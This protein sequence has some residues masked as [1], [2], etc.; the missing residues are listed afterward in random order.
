MKETSDRPAPKPDAAPVRPAWLLLAWTFG[1]GLAVVLAVR[2]LTGPAS[3]SEIADMPAGSPQVVACLALAVFL[4]V[5]PP[6]VA[7]AL[8]VRWK[9]SLRAHGLRWPGASTILVAP[10]VGLALML[11]ATALPL[12]VGIGRFDPAGM[13]EVQRL[14]DA[15]RFV[16]ALEHKLRIEEGVQPLLREVAG[17]LAGGLLMGLLLAPFVEFPWRG[18]LQSQLIGLGFAVSSAAAALAA[19]LWWSAPMLLTPLVAGEDRSALPVRVATYAL[20]G[21]VLSWARVATGS[22]LPGG[23]IVATTSALHDLP[24][25]AVRGG[26]HLQ[27][28]L[29]MLVAVALLAIPAVLRPPLWRESRTADPRR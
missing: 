24:L 1:P 13:G 5:L 28:E 2:L 20:L 11:M 9:L 12:I 22:V 3:G 4:V 21:L 18:V 7:A 19:A 23:V 26:T 8:A 29:C 27:M 16:E 15:K 10:F 25:M 17:G 14:G 6:I